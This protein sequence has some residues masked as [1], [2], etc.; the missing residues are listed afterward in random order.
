MAYKTTH[1]RSFFYY[2]V[3]LYYSRVKLITSRMATLS[4]TLRCMIL[5]ALGLLFSTC[6]VEGTFENL[7]KK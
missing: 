5:G 6:V 4:T 2:C 1:L 3:I 7:R